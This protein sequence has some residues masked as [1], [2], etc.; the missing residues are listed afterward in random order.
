MNRKVLATFCF[1]YLTTV[2]QCRGLHLHGQWQSTKFF[3]FLGRFGFQ[4]TNIHEKSE[5]QGYIYG[6][7]TSKD[8]ITH[9]IT[10]VVVDSEYFLYFFGNRSLPSR[11]EACSSMFKKIETIA[12]DRT[13]NPV[14]EE[15]FLRKIPCTKDALCDEE[16]NPNWVVS[17]YQ[18]TYRVQDTRQP[19]YWFI[20]MVS[21]YHDDSNSSNCFW[22]YDSDQQ[23]TI[24]YDIWLVN[25]HPD[26]KDANPFEHQ[27]SFE[28]HDVF[29]LYL[30]FFL[31]Y[32]F[33]LPIQLYA[34]SQQ[35][36]VIPLLLTSCICLEYVGVIFNFV[37]VTKFAFD[38]EGVEALKV[39]GNFID[40][41]S[42]CLFMLLLL[43]IVK[44]WNI[45]RPTLPCQAWL[46][47]LSVWCAYSAASIA[48]FV[49]NQVEVD[50]ISDIDEWQTWPGF[51][52]LAFRIIIM[53]WFLWELRETFHFEHGEKKTKFYLHFGA[54]FL[55]WFVYLPLVA[56][57]CTQLSALWRYKTI[58][59]VSYAADFLSLCVM[60]HLLWP[61][62]SYLFFNLKHLKAQN[63]QLDSLEFAGLSN[64]PLL[65]MSEDASDIDFF[66]VEEEDAEEEDKEEHTK[67]NGCSEKTVSNGLQNR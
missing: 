66:D 43:L 5:T 45:T 25:G 29:E 8:G 22:S 33:V 47:L 57:I 9:K 20:S 64:Y 49:W 26:H 4:Q 1:I 34:L 46:V 42:Q 14:G 24:D 31:A 62:R 27:F 41:V 61:T 54:G 53:L 15:D 6:N 52:I 55:V 44:G 28:L 3:K 12:W 23:L 21:C 60:I 30:V 11:S 51:L 48:L 63:L 38:G 39:A 67:L 16:D 2:L 10:F 18:F 13:C 17:G 36:H 50:S 19:R 35:R 37:H 58:L 7:L 32:T 65:Q 59:S 40:M 56:I